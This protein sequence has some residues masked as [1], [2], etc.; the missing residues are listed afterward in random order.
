MQELGTHFKIQKASIREKKKRKEKYAIQSI[1][2]GFIFNL[3]IFLLL[4]LINMIK[5]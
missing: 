3:E 1:H 2:P 4:I 5:I